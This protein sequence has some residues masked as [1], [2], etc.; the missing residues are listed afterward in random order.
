MTRKEQ[1]QTN[2]SNSQCNK[3]SS[4]AKYTG[5][6]NGKV[7]PLPLPAP[8]HTPLTHICPIFSHFSPSPSSENQ[9]T[10]HPLTTHITQSHVA[11]IKLT[12]QCVLIQEAQD[13]WHI[14]PQLSKALEMTHIIEGDDMLVCACSPILPS[15]IKR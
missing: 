2:E 10:G 6:I 5:S 12:N 8:T 1:T 11:W 15:S 9:H 7:T 4:P 3:L 14:S 13:L